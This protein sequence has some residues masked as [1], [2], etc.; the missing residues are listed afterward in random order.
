MTLSCTVDGH[1]I[2]DEW[3]RQLQQENERLRKALSARLQQLDE[4]RLCLE[5]VASCST[6]EAC[7]G[8]AERALG[9]SGHP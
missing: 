3:I 6:C 9:L 2:T 7:R 4:A 8:A 5:G 1:N